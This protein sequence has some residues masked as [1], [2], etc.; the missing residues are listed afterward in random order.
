M[1]F[2]FYSEFG[3][4]V[5]LATYLHDV[6]GH[7]IHLFIKEKDYKSIGDG[8]VDRTDDWH[9]YLNKGYVW[10]F[11][12]TSFGGLQDWLRGE[13]EAVVGGTKQGDELENERQLNQRWF[14]SAGFKQVESRNFHDIKS[15]IRF[16]EVR[17]DRRWIL[18][19]NGDAPKSISYLGKFD[20]S[21]D[22]LYHLQQLQHG[23][24]EAEY[25]KFDCD[26]MEVVEG[27]E[28]GAT[29]FFN[30]HKFMENAMGK[31]VGFLD[32]EEKKEADGGL[33]ETCGEMG[34]AF[35]GC[36]EDVPLFKKILLRPKIIDRLKDLN[37][38][39]VFNINC[40]ITDKDEIVALEPTMRFGMP[41]TSYEFMEGLNVD[42]GTILD[43]LARG[44]DVPVEIYSGVGMVM[45]VVAKPFPLEV[46]VEPLGTSSGERL[47]ILGRDGLPIKDFTDSQK[48]HIHLYNF[49]RIKDEESGEYS[50][51]VAT[52]NGYLLTVTKKGTNIKILR[53]QLIEYIK[54]NI[55]LNGMKYRQDIGKRAEE[56]VETL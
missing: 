26:L 36:T 48:E 20:G 4:T 17:S 6:Y 50:Y 7:E 34:T 56:F 46:D 27:T 12:S 5:D 23:W 30:G 3:E 24:N 39:G 55:F 29:A 15:A 33:G 2:V 52:K 44:K 14:K 22:L 1:K 49:R 11:D 32:F 43:A 42:P 40:I 16:V 37:F 21:T 19:Q 53:H 28:V 18:K 10:V 51:R 47:W 13:G 54:G 45:C 8:I 35:V 9:E 31:V 25:G 41:A 38:R